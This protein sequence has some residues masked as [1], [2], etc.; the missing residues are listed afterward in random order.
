MDTTFYSFSVDFP[1]Y[2][3]RML[4]IAECVA[5]ALEYP[6]DWTLV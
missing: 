4:V 2:K 6:S 1:E 3:Y 5:L